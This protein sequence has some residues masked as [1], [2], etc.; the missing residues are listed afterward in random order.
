MQAQIDDVMS[1]IGDNFD[2]MEQFGRHFRDYAQLLLNDLQHEHEEN[3]EISLNEK[4]VYIEKLSKTV[5][6]IYNR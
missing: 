6:L 5:T 4:R 2:L 3:D 1:I